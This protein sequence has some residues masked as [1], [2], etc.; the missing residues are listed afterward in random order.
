MIFSNGQF[1]VK[2]QCYYFDPES[3]RF[4]KI[5][6]RVPENAIIIHYTG[7]YK[8]PETTAEG[9]KEFTISLF[10]YSEPLETITGTICKKG[11]NEDYHSKMRYMIKRASELFEKRKQKSE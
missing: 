2:E 10:E 6:D 4:K 3:K 9:I 5:K 11:S 1:D 7:L 8:S